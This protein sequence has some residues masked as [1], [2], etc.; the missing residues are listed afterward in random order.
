[1]TRMLALGALA[2]LL[3]PAGAAADV[4]RVGKPSLRVG[5]GPTLVLRGASF[6]AGERVKVTVA[7]GRRIAKD[8]HAND[9]GS[10]TVRFRIPYDR[11]NSS[12]TALAVGSR[13]SQARLKLPELMCPP[14]L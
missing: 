7:V 9:G 8:T 2:M 1:M 14:R 10:F 13:G 5:V 6:A 11:C 12:L 3:L 4:N